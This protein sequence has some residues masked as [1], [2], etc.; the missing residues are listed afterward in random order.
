MLIISG[1]AQY[2]LASNQY[3][4]GDRHI[5]TLFSANENFEG[6]LGVIEVFLNQRGW[7]DILIMETELRDSCKEIEHSI[8]KQGFEKAA[9]QGLALVVNNMALES[10]TVAA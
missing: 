4:K 9:M 5:F 3:K 1:S 6:S 8:L 10:T 7:H 2:T